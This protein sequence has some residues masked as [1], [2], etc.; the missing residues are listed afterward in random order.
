MSRT[1]QEDDERIT[2]LTAELAEAKAALGIEKTG[3]EE[4]AR[5]NRAIRSIQALL[6]ST[7]S[8][9]ENMQSALTE[10]S[11]AIGSETA[12]LSLSKE[13]R[14]AVAYVHGFPRE[15]VGAEMND[16]QEPHAVLAISTGEPVAIDDAM[17]DPRVNRRHMAEWGVRSVLVVPVMSKQNAV[18]VFFFNFH[19]SPFPFGEAHLEF[20]RGLAS[21]MSLA[22]DNTR[23]LEGLRSA[24]TARYEE[25]ESKTAT[26]NEANEFLRREMEV[27]KKA[28]EEIR[29][30]MAIMETV[31]EGIFL[32]GADDYVIKWA[33]SK[34]EKMFGYKPGEMVGLSVDTLNAPTETTPAETRISIVNELL[35]DGEWHGEVENIKKDGTHFW[36]YANASL[37]DHPEFGKVIVST[38]SD[39]TERKRAE[40]A[41]RESEEK[42]RNLFAIEKDALFFIDKETGS[43]LDVNDRT[44]LLYGYTRNE[45]LKMKHIDVSA[46]PEASLASI[47]EATEGIESR[48]HRK[49]DGTV[50]PVD[51]TATHFLFRGRPVVLGAARDVS[52]RKQAEEELKRHRDRLGEMV[53]ERTSDLEAKSRELEGLNSALKVILRQREEDR[54]DLEDRLISNVQDLIVPYMTKLKKCSDDSERQSLLNVVQSSLG[55]II[56]PFLRNL[57]RLRLTPRETEVAVL[58]KEGRSTKEIAEILR[59]APSSVES[60]RKRIRNRLKLTQEKV[61]L[62]A[63][64]RS[65]D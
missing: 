4:S 65:L 16:E 33:N 17:H 9:A 24:L 18:G 14:W 7:A 6:H 49:K 11:N 56:S 43:I 44:C 3:R 63:Y 12:A 58:V 48:L 19:K 21:S 13:G 50:F 40:Q 37:F 34:F 41:L 38:H 52:A 26:L 22:L 2:G 46:E 64:L 1:S 60:C 45:L 10:A 35:R 47:E 39:I 57:N 15:V 51:I 31:G 29:L 28:E 62:Q 42:Y 8:F 59:L 53:K 20:A 27:R 54:K 32:I 55:E 36:C 5:F 61:N 30:R 23:L 25:S